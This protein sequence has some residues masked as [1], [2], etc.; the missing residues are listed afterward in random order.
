LAKITE[1]KGSL[2]PAFSLSAASILGSGRR[3]SPRDDLAQPEVANVAPEQA[4]DGSSQF[5]VSGAQATA[6]VAALAALVVLAVAV[7]VYRRSRALKISQP[8]DCEMIVPTCSIPPTAANES[9]T[10][11]M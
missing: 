3:S 1:L 11:M 2:G 10:D 4:Q 9:G 5:G 7:V 8:A 6:A